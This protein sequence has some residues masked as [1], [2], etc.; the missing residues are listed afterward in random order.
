MT[1]SSSLLLNTGLHNSLKDVTQRWQKKKGMGIYLSD[2][3]HDCLTN[4]RFADDVLLFLTSKEQL[5][6]CCTT[7]RKVLKKWVSGFNQSNRNPEKKRKREILVPVD[8]IPATGDDRNQE[9]Y[10]GSLGDVSQVQA[11]TDIEKPH[12]QTSSPTVRCSNNSDDMLRIWN[13]GTHQRARKND[14]IGATQNA[15]SHHQNQKT[16]QKDRETQS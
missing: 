11:G 12:A 8:Y 16:I 9:W 13:M 10:Q 3:D 7:S 4:L 6:K 5:Q 1:L 15:P 2:H 14:T